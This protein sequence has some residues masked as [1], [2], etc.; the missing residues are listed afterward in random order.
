MCG[1][2]CDNTGSAREAER[3]PLIHVEQQQDRF[4]FNTFLLLLRRSVNVGQ[5]EVVMVMDTGGARG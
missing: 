2:P 4:C 1:P 5:R 3:Q